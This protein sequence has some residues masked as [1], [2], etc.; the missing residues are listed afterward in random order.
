MSDGCCGEC[1]SQPATD[2]GL[3]GRGPDSAP[4]D[5]LTIARFRIRG[6][7][8]AE[9]T[10]ALTATVGSLAGV[11]ELG[12]NLLIGTMTVGYDAAVADEAA[13][14]DAVRRAGL[15]AQAIAATRADAANRSAPDWWSRRGR[16][17]LC[18]ASGALAGSGFVTHALLHG[19]VGHALTGGE[20]ADHVFPPTVVVLYVAAAVA[21]SWFVAPKALAAVR[22]MRADMNLLMTIAV[23]GA[24]LIGQWFEAATVAFLFALSLLLESW[25]V[26]R[27]RRAIRALVALAPPVARCLRPEDGSLVERPAADVAV[28]SVISVRPGERIPLDGVVTRGSTTVNQAPITGES[29]PIV[30]RTGD[31]VF[32]GT[33]NQDGA[34]EFRATK[35]AAD[36]TLS[37]IIRMVEEAQSRRAPVEQWVERFA[38]YYTPTMMALALVVALVPP[39]VFGGGWSR[40]FYEALVLLVIACPCALVISTPVSIVAGLTSAAR[41]GLL[42]KGGAFLEAAARIRVFAMDKTGT[43]TRGFPEVQDVVP[44]NGHDS[45]ELLARAAALEAH[46]EHPLAAA[47]LRK[48]AAEKVTPATAEDYRSLKGR[49]AEARIDGHQFWL[50][51]HRLLHDKGCENPEIHERAL[52]MEDA[53]H[54]VVVVGNDRHVCGLIGVADSV[55]ESAAATVSALKASGVRYVA[56]LTGDNQGT[57]EAVAK[58]VGA[59]EVRAELL[60]EDKLRAVLEIQEKHGPTA[61]VG[62][63][64]NDAPALAAATL[65][66]AMGAAGTDAAIETADIALLSDDLSRLPWLVRHSRRTTSMIRQNI[67]FALG[68]KALFMALA[69]L[70]LATLWMAIAADMGVSLLVVFNALRLLGGERVPSGR[71]GLP[72][73]AASAVRSGQG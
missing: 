17:V 39:L 71:G 51:S 54:S 22:R 28:G 9:E 42:V 60:P 33:I 45:S 11:R 50:G 36:T 20:G 16:A 14:R 43:L 53:G 64:V 47:I 8:C 23:V 4:C 34:I 38:R 49:G 35:V 12:F 69:F 58:A 6:M 52:R 67:F 59:D 56:L 5:R 27:A 63:G 3:P 32:A 73:A 44:L 41:A 13:I 10:N 62:D 61:M 24:L 65:G 15:E 37:R 7:D 26:E 55:R 70:N 29:L 30:K 57:A 40:W 31:E 1:R 21:G 25:S 46:S 18:L 72:G 19:D 68:V 48:A 66:I 2:A